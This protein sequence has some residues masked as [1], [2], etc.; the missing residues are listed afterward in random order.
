MH[1]VT[2]VQARTG[3]T[4]LPAKVLA[5]LGGAPLVA[6]VLERVARA[7]TVAE[8]V[9][10]VPE[11]AGDDELASLG[12]RL[13]FPVVRGPDADVLERYR[14]AAEVTAA[15]VVVRITAD[16]PF[17]DPALVDAAVNQLRDG[18]FD[19]VSNG[20]A[21]YLRGLDVEVMTR[22]TLERAVEEATA[23]HDRA[24]VTAYVWTRP[25]E[26]RIGW[27]RW[28]RDYSAQRWTVDTPDDLA[29]RA[30]VVGTAGRSAARP[31]ADDPRDRR[32]RSRAAR[33]ERARR[34]EGTRRWL[35]ARSRSCATP[36]VW[37]DSVTPVDASRSQRRGTSVG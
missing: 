30:R 9:L 35:N 10:A 25:D 32:G 33:D 7:E 8:T 24:H 29:F 26:F 22:A 31:M 18:G 21:G 37:P 11:G 2:V 20:T 12:A 13:G 16:C 34:A 19:Y 4:R 3:S 28:D 1:V 15:H 5:D 14:L 6:R 23:P 27:A 36:T 17:V